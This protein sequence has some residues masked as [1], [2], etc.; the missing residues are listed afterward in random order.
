MTTPGT[1]SNIFR[2]LT[3]NLRTGLLVVADELKWIALKG[4]RSLEIRQMEKR[5][6]EERAA[7][8][9]SVAQAVAQA[10]SEPASAPLDEAARL[11]LKQI[12]FLQ[13]ELAY[14]RTERDRMR[15]EML[16]RRRSTLAPAQPDPS[17]PEPRKE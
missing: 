6:T 17:Q 15:Q 16:A 5:L 12:S 2:D 10:G 14:L 11:C 1:P 13:E 9:R 3:G 7:L 8:G 4:L